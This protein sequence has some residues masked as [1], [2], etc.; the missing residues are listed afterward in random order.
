MTFVAEQTGGI[1][2]KKAVKIRTEM[3]W[4]PRRPASDRYC[5]SHR[6]PMPLSK[7]RCSTT[8]RCKPPITNLVHPKTEMAR[9]APPAPSLSLSNITGTEFEIER[10]LAQDVLALFTLPRRQR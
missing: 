6:R 3:T 1:L 10:Q 7:L 5:P 4:P 9:L 2:G 8:E